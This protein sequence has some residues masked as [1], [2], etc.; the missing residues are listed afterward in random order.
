M[1]KNKKSFNLF[2]IE[3]GEGLLVFILFFIFFFIKSSFV[4]FQNFS[5]TTFLKR[6][7]IEYLPMVFLINGVFVFL[8]LGALARLIDKFSRIKFFITIFFATAGVYILLWFLVGKDIP[9]VY[10]A[11]NILGGLINIIFSLTF[12]LLAGDVFDTRQSKRLFALLSAGGILGAIVG[13]FVSPVVSRVF[14]M[15]NI[16]FV[17]AGILVL[18]A[19]FLLMFSKKLSAGNKKIFKKETEKSKGGIWSIIKGSMLLKLLILIVF[20]PGILKPI[21]EYQFIYLVNNTYVTEQGLMAFWGMFKGI[22]NVLLFILQV[23]ITGKL[24]TS[25]GLSR[26]MYFL[27]INYAIYFAALTFKFELV[28]GLYGKITTKIF[29][30]A[31]QGPA[32]KALYGFF[33]D[34]IRGR[35]SLFMKGIVGKL[36]SITGS[37]MLVLLLP[38]LGTQNISIVAGG[39]ALI[40]IIATINFKRNYNNILFTAISNRQLNLDDLSQA[41]I[42]EMI[43]PDIEKKMLERITSDNS[44]GTLM[45][46]K[47]LMM[48]GK[49]L[50]TKQI[51][52]SLDKFS[53]T[54]K[55]EIMKLLQENRDPEI[56]AEIKQVAGY[57]SSKLFPYYLEIL[58]KNQLND[59]IAL[60]NLAMKSDKPRVYVAGIS[61][62]LNY[63]NTSVKLHALTRLKKLLNSNTR[64]YILS[65]IIG[66]LHWERCAP[67]IVEHIN[68]P[69]VVVRVAVVTA[70]GNMH[71]YY[72]VP[73]LIKTLTEDSFNIKAACIVALGKIARKDSPEQNNALKAII[74]FLG[75][76]RQN[77]RKIAVDSIKQLGNKGLAL[78]TA[79]INS[80][81]SL[82]VIE[83]VLETLLAYKNTEIDGEAIFADYLKQAYIAKAKLALLPTIDKDKT[84]AL[85][86]LQKLII[87]D[88][89]TLKRIVILALF[90]LKDNRKFGQA[91]LKTIRKSIDSPDKKEVALAIEGIENLSPANY[92]KA[93]TL[94]FEEKP[95]EIQNIG[96]QLF[97]I[98]SYSFD[99]IIKPLLASDIEINR[100]IAMF[101]IK[102]INDKHFVPLIEKISENKNDPLYET[103]NEIVLRITNKE[104]IM[105]QELTILEKIFFLEKVSIFEFLSI[106]ELTAIAQITRELS[107][108]LGTTIFK[109]GDSGDKM[110]LVVDG[111]IDIKKEG[112]SRGVRL[113][114]I[115]RNEFLGEMALFEKKTRSATAVATSATRL[116]EITGFD[117]E[118]IMNEYPSIPIKICGVLSERLRETA[119]NLRT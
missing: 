110:Y 82:D 86:F 76:K 111:I 100:L 83:G 112:D 38:L 6:F 40:A 73:T 25:I 4:L 91:R 115:G 61:C 74:P 10:P 7:G 71:Y 99:N 53:L 98:D 57:F 23:F 96:K 33:P 42:K 34:S 3:K 32:K 78:L 109:E 55:R 107:Y 95:A 93:T 31:F 68:H 116:L 97:A 66:K 44:S 14:S 118:E 19:I 48:A 62:G 18:S 13:N 39:L 15:N 27:P 24:F 102:E 60:I 2:N 45:A 67:M 84:P 90:F 85:F 47:F 75:D 94:L 65:A 106:R 89:Q 11:M 88:Y 108:I 22:F 79:Q 92:K 113:A 46:A 5:D 54:N 52:R 58:S 35:V 20:I 9:L 114:R 43:T 37:G 87:E 36:G 59:Y 105:A 12:W 63:A 21:V 1:A 50:L 16:L 30:N 26:I 29:S 80:N 8:F 77:L 72:S 81:N 104:L 101:T 117:F 51:I 119:A 49:P 41:S 70:L 17:S 56:I 64:A 28:I 69:S 103:A